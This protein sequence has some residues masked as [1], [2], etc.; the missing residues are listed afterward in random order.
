[1]KTHRM[2]CLMLLAWAVASL[3]AWA[4]EPFRKH[5]YDAF[6]MTPPPEGSIIM[7]GNSI[8]D[9]HPWV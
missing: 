2:L 8:T 4:D 6:R 7:L 5:R 3:T 1:M 9:M